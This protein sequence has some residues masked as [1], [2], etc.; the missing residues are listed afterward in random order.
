MAKLIATVTQP[1]RMVGYGSHAIIKAPYRTLLMAG[2]G[3][4]HIDHGYL[5]MLQN[6]LHQTLTQ[7]CT[8][9]NLAV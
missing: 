9:R 6:V 1:A 3:V 8:P 5:L 7:A 4:I 2:T